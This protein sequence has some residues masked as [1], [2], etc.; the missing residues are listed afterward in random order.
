MPT[1]VIGSVARKRAAGKGEAGSE[2][3]LVAAKQLQ[4]ELKR[5]LEGEPPYDIFVRW[6]PLGRQSIGWEPR[7]E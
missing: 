4:D 5:I 6:K 1:S 3:R 2:G 7:S